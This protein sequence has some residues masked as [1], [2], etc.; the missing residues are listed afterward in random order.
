[1]N[2]LPAALAP[3]FAKKLG[4]SISVA[5]LAQSL[6]GKIATQEGDSKWISNEENLV[7]AHRMRAFCDGI[8]VGTKT[9]ELDRPQ[10]TVRRV[11]GKNPTRIVLGNSSPDMSSIITSGQQVIRISSNQFK[12]DDQ[13]TDIRMHETGGRIPC[14]DILEKLFQNGI[15]SVYVEGGAITVSNFIQDKAVDIL[16]IHIAPIILGSGKPAIELPYIGRIA[17]AIQF[18]DFRIQEMGD[19]IMFVGTLK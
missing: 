18:N 4:R 13:I 10:L 19:T 14:Q 16:Q 15:F 8:M 9:L 5:H 2:Y 1:M 12:S 17:H 3:Y 7:H 11:Q 6:D